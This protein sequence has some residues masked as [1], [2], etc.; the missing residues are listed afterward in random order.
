[1]SAHARKLKLE[2]KRKSKFAKAKPSSLRN[3]KHNVNVELPISLVDTFIIAQHKK[4][5][6]VY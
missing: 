1:M 4:S 6:K 2:K 5:I 3:A